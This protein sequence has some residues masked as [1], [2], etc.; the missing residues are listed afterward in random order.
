[1]KNFLLKIAL[2]GAMF[3]GMALTGCETQDPM[4]NVAMGAE[5]TSTSL[6]SATVKVMT[7]GITEYAYTVAQAGATKPTA[8]AVFANGTVKSL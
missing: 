4:E 3:A 1:M 6:T 8:D 7:N 5:V 2:I